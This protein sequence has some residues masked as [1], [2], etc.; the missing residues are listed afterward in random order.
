[1]SDD[2]RRRWFIVVALSGFLPALSGCLAHP[3]IGIAEKILEPHMP[4]WEQFFKIEWEPGEWRGHPVVKG[5]LY[6]TSP[7]TIG[8]VQLLVDALDAAGGILGQ[9]VSW[10]AG[11]IGPF[12][13][14]YFVADAPLVQAAP[15]QPASYRVRVYSYDEILGPR[16]RG[17]PL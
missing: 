2:R 10:V 8:D 3:A 9:T 14:Q 5:Y 12:S 11:P 13:R 6:N 4:G 16:G 1:V 7:K 15:Q 17:W